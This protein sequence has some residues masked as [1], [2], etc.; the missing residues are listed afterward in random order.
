ML[1][2]KN[3]V[4]VQGDQVVQKSSEYKWTPIVKHLN[5]E[6]KFT[7][8]NQFIALMKT[9]DATEFKYWVEHLNYVEAPYVL[10]KGVMKQNRID[11]YKKDKIKGNSFKKLKGDRIKK[12]TIP[13][14][15]VYGIFAKPL[16]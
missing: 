1:E 6:V 5:C 13:V 9:E 12:Y 11:W 2:G 10:A 7:D 8:T 14:Q 4:Y 15:V 3:I 16:I